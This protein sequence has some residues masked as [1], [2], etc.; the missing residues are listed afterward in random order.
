[1]TKSIEDFDFSDQAVESSTSVSQTKI[2]PPL[3]SNGYAVLRSTTV[4]RLDAVLKIAEELASEF[5]RIESGP[6]GRCDSNDM[7]DLVNSLER[8]RSAFQ[9]AKK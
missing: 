7:E 6:F 4:A 9:Q 1:M 2:P 8:A 3:S 5:Y